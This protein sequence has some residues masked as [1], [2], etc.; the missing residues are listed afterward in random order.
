MAN[1]GNNTLKNLMEDVILAEALFGEDRVMEAW[2][3]L[4]KITKYVDD[5]PEK[6]DIKAIKKRVKEVRCLK[7]AYSLCS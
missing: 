1:Y 4:K 7:K 5:M 3:L 6:G 2:T